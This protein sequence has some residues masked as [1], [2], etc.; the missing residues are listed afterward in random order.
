MPWEE[1]LEPKQ[2]HRHQRYALCQT[3]V[4]YNVQDGTMIGDT[5]EKIQKYLEALKTM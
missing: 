3:V 2:R 4:S 5:L 1:L